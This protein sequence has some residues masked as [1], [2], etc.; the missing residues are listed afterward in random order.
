VRRKTPRSIL[1]S[2]TVDYVGLLAGVSELLEAACHT[3]ARSV[4]TILTTHSGAR[5]AFNRDIVKPGC[6]G[7]KHGDLYNRLFRDRQ[8]GDYIEFTAF[9]A[10]YVQ[11]K[12][13]ACE[14]FLAAL[15]PLLKSL[16]LD[17][18]EREL[19]GEH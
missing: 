13:A 1:A 7:R 6:L 9:D 3:V 15:R 10:S 18:G 17:E 2:P 4:N 16:P 14:E 19:H 11:E 12:I 8:E 5:A